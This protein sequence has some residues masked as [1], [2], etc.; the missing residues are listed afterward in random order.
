MWLDALV[1]TVATI[2]GAI[3]AVT[4]F[5]I[6]SLLTPVMAMQVDT[7]LA[8]AAVSIPHVVGTAV[9]FFLQP[10]R[11]DRRVLWHFGLTSAA[12]GLAGASLSAWASNRWLSVIFGVLLLFAAASET[13]GLAKR[14]RFRGSM[15]WI[16]GALSGLLGGLVGNQGG[17]RSAALLAFDLPKQSFVATATAIGLFV[18]GARMPVYVFTQHAQL[19]ELWRPIAVATVGVTL[20]TVVGSHALSRL[21]ESWFRRVLA[22]VLASLGTAMLIRGLRG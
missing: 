17:I 5:G 12:G 3:A 8:V 21:P 1:L 2:A 7:R 18:D 20:G 4:G 9:R 15:A 6:G 16:A 11:V 19:S 22:L 14:M 13:S 10:G